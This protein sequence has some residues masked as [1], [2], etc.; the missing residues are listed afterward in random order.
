MEYIKKADNTAEGHSDSIR[1]TVK[2]ILADIEARRE[3]AVA[4]LAKKFDGWDGEFILSPEKNKPS[5]TRCRTR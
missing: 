2:D 1:G 3:L 5:S 4:E